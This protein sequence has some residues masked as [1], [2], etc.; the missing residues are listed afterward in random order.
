MPR[1]WLR[2]A[3][4]FA[5]HSVRIGKGNPVDGQLAPYLAEADLFATNDRRLARIVEAIRPSSPAPCAAGA[6][7]DIK[8]AGGSVLDAFRE[9][10]R[11]VY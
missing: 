7:V 1:A 10:A 8:D 3:V 2:W 11:I 4:D 9:A 6:F 5:Q